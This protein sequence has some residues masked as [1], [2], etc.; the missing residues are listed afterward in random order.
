MTLF[1]KVTEEKER[2]NRV[3]RGVDAGSAHGDGAFY[4]DFTAVCK[5]PFDAAEF[6]FLPF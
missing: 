3:R 1:Y 4:P 6:D 5:T 2:E